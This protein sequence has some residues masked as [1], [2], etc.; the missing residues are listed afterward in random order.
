[1][2]FDSIDPVPETRGKFDRDSKEEEIGKCKRN[3]SV[4]ED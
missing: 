1:M 4:M 2:Q 3:T